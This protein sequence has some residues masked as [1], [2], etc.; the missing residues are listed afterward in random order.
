M[1]WYRLT[2]LVLPPLCLRNT[3]PL[4]AL[5]HCNEDLWLKWR[6]NCQWATLPLFHGLAADFKCANKRQGHTDKNQWPWRWFEGCNKRQGHTDK[7]QWP[8]CS[9]QGCNKSQGHTDRHTCLYPAWPALQSSPAL[10]LPLA[11]GPRAC[12]QCFA[13]GKWSACGRRLSL[14]ETWASGWARPGD[15]SLPPQAAAASATRRQS[16]AIKFIS[17]TED[18]DSG[19]GIKC[20]TCRREL[21]VTHTAGIYFPRKRSHRTYKQWSTWQDSWNGGPSR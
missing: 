7:N 11:A 14:S 18:A 1:Q 9:F 19:S 21:T 2:G 15:W 13:R 16:H 17:V 5:N 10:H 6:V 4:K 12:G 20:L 8:W 3:A